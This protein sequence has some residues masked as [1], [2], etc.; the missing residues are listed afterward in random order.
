[1]FIRGSSSLPSFRQIIL[2]HRLALA[3]SGSR[4]DL[5]INRSTT[6]RRCF[7][8]RGDDFLHMLRHGFRIALAHAA[9]EIPEIHPLRQRLASL[10]L[11]VFP[12]IVL[13]RLDHTRRLMPRHAEGK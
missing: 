13:D 10:A 7:I 5:K 4:D 8:N 11:Q 2:L 1:M 12:H 6:T 3:V 9:V